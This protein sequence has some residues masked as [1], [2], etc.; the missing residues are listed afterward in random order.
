[1]VEEV[2]DCYAI[3]TIHNWDVLHD[4]FDLFRTTELQSI[5]IPHHDQHGQL[6]H[7]LH[8]FRQFLHEYLQEKESLIIKVFNNN[9][10]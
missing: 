10:I 7:L 8:P 5:F 2:F 1:M 4:L 3:G 9:R 6:H